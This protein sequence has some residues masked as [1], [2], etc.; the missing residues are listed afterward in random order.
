MNFKNL[1][2]A[3]QYFKNEDVCRDH[4]VKMRWPDGKIVCPKCGQKGAYHYA[5]GL[6]FK[7]KSQTC[8]NRFSA[9]VGSMFENTKL[10]LSKWFVAIWLITAHKKGISSLQISRDLG[11]GQKAGW[12]LLH[13]IRQM[14]ADNAPEKLDSIVEIDETYVGGKFANMNRKRRKKYQDEG[15]DNKAAV[16]GIVQRDGKAKLKVIGGNTFKEVVRAHVKNEALIVTDTHNGYAGLANEYEAHLSVNHSQMEFKNG[17]AYTNTVE[18]FFSC[19]KRSIIGIYHQVSV[20]HLEAYCNETAYRYNT[21]KI[22][23]VERF[24]LT[25]KNCAGRLTYKALTKK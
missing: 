11:I 15:V 14:L 23:D 20:K 16:M 22:K 8:K 2:D 25:M 13:R 4:L 3:I 1:Q 10:P 18:G 6:W 5:N 21:R 9:T 12:F 19:L 24:E 7:C 17:L